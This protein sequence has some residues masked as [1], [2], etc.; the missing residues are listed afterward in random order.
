MIR[1]EDDGK[2]SKAFLYNKN[3]MYSVCSGK[4]KNSDCFVENVRK[5]I[6]KLYDI[7][8]SENDFFNYFSADLDEP[9]VCK[10]SG[11]RVVCQTI[12]VG[13]QR[14]SFFIGFVPKEIFETFQVKEDKHATVSFKISECEHASAIV[15]DEMFKFGVEIFTYNVF[16]NTIIDHYPDRISK[17][18]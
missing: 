2:L 10:H 8:L 13:E 11:V 18:Q 15:F 12:F 5:K 9:Q 14:R 3:G 7:D 16:N 6:L 17:Y 1:V 4:L